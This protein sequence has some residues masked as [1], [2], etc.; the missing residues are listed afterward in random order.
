MDLNFTTSSVDAKVVVEAYGLYKEAKFREAI[1]VLHAILDVEPN[2]WQA[3]LF[4]A[5]CQFET[6]QPAA[7]QR[8]FR[9]IYDNCPDAGV[10]QRACLALQ[11]VNSELQRKTSAVPL[12]FGDVV[13]RAK[14]E[15]AVLRKLVG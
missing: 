15:V 3:R 11:F 14:P 12:E 1:P 4:L 8:A 6:A 10:K 7:A 2:N 9:H 5:V 13:Q